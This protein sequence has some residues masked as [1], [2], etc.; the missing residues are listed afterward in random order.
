MQ[1]LING[2]TLLEL[3]I[4]IVLLA[5]MVVGFFSIDL[6]THSQVLI[7]EKRAKLQNEISYAL[8]HMSKAM[9][10]VS[11]SKLIGQNP[12]YITPNTDIRMYIDTTGN[13]QADTWIAYR[14][15]TGANPSDYQIR[16]CSN[17]PNSACGTCSSS[18]GWEVISR[19]ILQFVPAD[20]EDNYVK[21]DMVARWQP[22]QPSS[23]DNPEVTMRTR[24]KLPSVSTN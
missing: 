9:N 16:Y 6:F 3:L 10:R 17:C 1:R 24:I 4:A 23:V 14:L 15:F 5:I 13:G 19:R 7:S 12:I 2:I 8:E 22:A 18:S 20:T 21:V 11:G